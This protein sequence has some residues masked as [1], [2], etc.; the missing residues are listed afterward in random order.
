MRH[1]R[2]RALPAVAGLVA[3]ATVTATVAASAPA[4]GYAAAGG[5]AASSAAGPTLRLI[6]AQHNITVQRFG[7]RVSL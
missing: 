3:A 7:K 2:R 5:A 1:V 6:A 4:F